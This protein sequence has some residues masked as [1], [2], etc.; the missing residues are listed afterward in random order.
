MKSDYKKLGKNTLL[1]AIGSFA[2]KALSFLLV[3]FYTYVL[4]TADYG[5]SD[6]IFTI[7]SMAW[8]MLTLLIDDAVLR[9]SLEKGERKEQIISIGLYINLIG[10]IVMLCFSPLILLVGSLR[11]FYFLFVLYYLSFAVNAFFSYALRGLEK[12]ALFSISGIITSVLII[13]C[14]LLFLLVFK[15]GIKGYLLSYIIAFS[16]T[17][18]IQ[19]SFGGFTR[20]IVPIRLID[21][22][23]RKEMIRY[24][25]PLIPNSISWWISNSSDKLIVTAVCGVSVNGLYAV[26]YKIPSLITTMSSIFSNA[27]QISAVD[28]FGSETNRKYFS[29]VYQRYS[30]AC[31]MLAAILISCNR[32]VCHIAFSKDFYSAWIFVPILLY[33]VTFQIMSGFLGTIYTT[34][35]KTKMVFISTVIAAG[36]NILLN[37]LFIPLFGA[38]GAA[39]ATCISYFIVWIIRVIDSRKIMILS[40]DWTKEIVCNIILFF[41]V[42]LALFDSNI[43]LIGSIVLMLLLFFL[44]RNIVCDVLKL[45]K[46]L[47]KKFKSLKDNK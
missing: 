7:S 47:I 36:I 14:N 2:Q 38:K 45:I 8:P 24:S 18:I 11:D 9:F 32:F 46:V 43:M 25:L 20:Y 3:P 13:S 33:S 5:I 12:T 22:D 15:W 31:M 6:L 21:K 1:F 16:L 44:K 19:F 4:S 30:A 23:K 28:G 17:G 42:I 35:K 41:Q 26:S 29:D 39:W 40:V 10:F 27:W 37:A 34:A